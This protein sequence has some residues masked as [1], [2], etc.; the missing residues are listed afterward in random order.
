MTHP[1]EITDLITGIV[2]KY[3]PPDNRIYYVLAY[4]PVERMR[5]WHGP[6]LSP[7]EAMQT[8][9]M[10][11]SIQEAFIVVRWSPNGSEPT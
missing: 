2:G 8:T 3:V 11:D 6:Y 9:A 7:E 5:V 10:W 4:T 1:T